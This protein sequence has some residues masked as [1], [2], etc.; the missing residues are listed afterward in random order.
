MIRSRENF[1]WR[2]LNSI[3][4]C[5]DSRRQTCERGCM[6]RSGTHGAKQA[7]AAR[8]RLLAFVMLAASVAAMSPALAATTYVYDDLGRVTQV[9]YD[10]GRQVTYNYDAAGNRTAV[11]TAT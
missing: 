3:P 1:R 4:I 9:T 8:R 6:M 2:I 5:L 7:H 11:V 10:N